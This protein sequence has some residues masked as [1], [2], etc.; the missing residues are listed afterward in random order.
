M[1]LIRS[2]FQDELDNVSQTLFD[3]SVMVS[4]SMSK[5]TKS[6]VT[7]DLK[8]AEEVITFDEKVDTVQ[9]DRNQRNKPKIQG[10]HHQ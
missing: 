3:L 5:A 4:D 1:P 6:V 8:L 2:V 7:K 10:Y 9:H